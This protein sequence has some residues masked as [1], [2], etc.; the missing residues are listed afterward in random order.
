LEFFKG[1]TS[2]RENP[3]SMDVKGGEVVDRGRIVDTGKVAN[4]ESIIID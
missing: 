1:S 4:R 2:S 3:F